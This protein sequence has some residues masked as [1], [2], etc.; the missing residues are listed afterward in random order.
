[1]YSHRQSP[2]SPWQKHLADWRRSG[3]DIGKGEQGQDVPIE[4]ADPE[5]G[6]SRFLQNVDAYTPDYATSHL[7][8][9]NCKNADLAFHNFMFLHS[10]KFFSKY[11]QLLQMYVICVLIKC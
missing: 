10:C 7:H 2:P 1:M 8:N 4:L 5:G 6:C 11:I 3:S 9:H